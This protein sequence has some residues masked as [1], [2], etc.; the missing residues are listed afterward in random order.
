MYVFY[1]DGLLILSPIS[2]IIVP[3]FRVLNSRLIS[4]L[5]GHDP[6]S[7][8]SGVMKAAGGAATYSII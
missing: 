1:V 5:H 4:V 3:T 2:S 6:E 8:L 7:T